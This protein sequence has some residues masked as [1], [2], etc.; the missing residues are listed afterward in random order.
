ML[1]DPEPIR[2]NCPKQHR[3]F[4]EK[5]LAHFAVLNANY[6]IECGNFKSAWQFLAD[7]P[8]GAILSVSYWRTVARLAKRVLLHSAHPPTKTLDG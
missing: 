5:A 7:F 2:Q 6:Q 4:L 8:R 3:A 1:L